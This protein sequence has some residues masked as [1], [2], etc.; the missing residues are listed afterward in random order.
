MPEGRVRVHGPHDHEVDHAAHSG[1]P[2]AGRL[3]L[4]T[5]IFAA[6]GAL[7]GDIAGATQKEALLLRD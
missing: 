7:Y 5:A 1:D 6:I 3:A 2:L 4:V